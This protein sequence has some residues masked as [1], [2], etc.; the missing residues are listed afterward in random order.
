MR[1]VEKLRFNPLSLL[2]LGQLGNTFTNSH[3]RVVP[4]GLQRAKICLGYMV[5]SALGLRKHPLNVARCKITS[6][7]RSFRVIRGINDPVRSVARCA[8][9]Y[10]IRM[11]SPGNPLNSRVLKSGSH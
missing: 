10:L 8:L 5:A 2:L 7:Q 9:E 11:K 3:L 1:N 4:P 6:A